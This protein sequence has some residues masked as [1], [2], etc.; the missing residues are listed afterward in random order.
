MI[1]DLAAGWLM[2]APFITAEQAA[3]N[4]NQERL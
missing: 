4:V 2:I 1:S 3:N